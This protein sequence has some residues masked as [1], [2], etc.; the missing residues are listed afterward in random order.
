MGSGGWG[1]GLLT[2]PDPSTAI[3]PKSKTGLNGIPVPSSGMYA[4]YKGGPSETHYKIELGFQ[5]DCANKPRHWSAMSLIWSDDQAK[6]GGGE[7]EIQPKV[8]CGF[9]NDLNTNLGSSQ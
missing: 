4:M 2:Y 6:C 9:Q 5:N 7:P 3:G 1:G 8:G